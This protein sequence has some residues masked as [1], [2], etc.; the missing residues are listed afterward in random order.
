MNG[1]V[2]VFFGW[3]FLYPVISILLITTNTTSYLYDPFW[4]I[5]GV[6]L[7]TATS[8]RYVLQ[9]KYT[10]RQNDFL[11]DLTLQSGNVND[12]N[13]F[14]TF[15]YSEKHKASVITTYIEGIYGYDF[16]LKLE[17][18]IER[19]FKYIGLNSECQSGEIRLDDT[20]YII[21]DD[22]SLCSLLQTNQEL[23][24]VIV[25]IFSSYTN[26]NFKV[27]NLQCFDGRIIVSASSKSETDN[28]TIASSF[29][30]EVAVLLKRT[31]D[32]LPSK[33]SI[34]ERM[35]REKSSQLSYTI[36]LISFA[37]IINGFMVLLMENTT[38]AI[39]PHIIDYSAMVPMA[40]KT[41]IILTLILSIYI[42]YT[43]RHSSRLISTLFQVLIIGAL[44][45]F[46]SSLVEIKDI[47]IH[48]DTSK[49]EI[50]N[51][52]LM[53]KEAIWH[54]KHG[55]NYIFH[56]IDQKDPTNILDEQVPHQ[57]YLQT[58]KGETLHIYKREGL[59]GFPWIEKII[60]QSNSP[61]VSSVP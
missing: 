23:R 17:G 18:K 56:L 34:N 36:L 12:I 19:F 48:L 3:I 54:P 61:A 41:T 52:T 22:S 13:F 28:E 9:K 40:I 37:L 50:I 14:Y 32:V 49:P 25:E 58:K 43:L 26:S 5:S 60:I 11:E 31:I 35:Y 2:V 1:L 7:I 16:S 6:L 59:L 44:G 47:N 45:F 10:K 24:N 51:Y 33:G 21:S 46:L 53:E 27:S 15:I 20:L 4:R 8:I 57:L 29:A 38:V 30:R 42:F 55:T 39:L